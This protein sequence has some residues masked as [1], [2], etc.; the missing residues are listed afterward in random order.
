MDI[1]VLGMVL[2]DSM[3]VDEISEDIKSMFIETKINNG[4]IFVLRSMKPIE[5]NY[6]LRVTS[7]RNR[8]SSPNMLKKSLYLHQKK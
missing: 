1:N 8:Y 6:G 2:C 4:E 3:K 7:W 5:C